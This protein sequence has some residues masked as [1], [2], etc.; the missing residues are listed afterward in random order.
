[1]DFRVLLYTKVLFMSWMKQFVKKQTLILEIMNIFW[2]LLNS[3]QTDPIK[4]KHVSV[5]IIEGND[6]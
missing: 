6:Q 5:V 1:M 4:Q 3:E 2:Q